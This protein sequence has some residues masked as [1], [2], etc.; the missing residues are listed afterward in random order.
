MHGQHTFEKLLRKL[1]HPGKPF[2]KRPHL[3][4]RA[5]V[6]L[7]GAG[8]T[9]SFLPNRLPAAPLI[10]SANATTKNTAQN[11][12]FVLLAGAPSQIDTFDLKMINGTTPASFAPSTINGMLW[13]TGTMPKLAA[14]LDDIAIVRSVRASAL[15]HGLSQSWVQIGRNPAAVL[16]SIS[17]NIGSVVAI[18][19]DA[20]RKPSQ[21]FP[22]F[23]ALNSAGASSQGYFSS[24]YAPFKVQ[25][26]TSGLRNVTN[27]NG[28][29]RFNTRFDFL[30]KLDDSLRVDSPYG[31][32]VSDY[33]DFY[34][35]AKGLMYNPV[36]TKAFSYTAADSTRYGSTTFGNSCLVAKQVL[37]ANQGTRFIQIT[38]GGWDNH[39]NI[40]Q[41]TVLPQI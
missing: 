41:P 17:P 24:S 37:E 13:P 33:D 5:F 6:N 14:L 7:A 39:T 27:T 22:T 8:L 32:P 30:H 12:I 23:L 31:Q 19:K 28:E 21:V 11:V 18:E 20:E 40:Y 36:V 2:F 29:T 1:P 3:T 38:Q 9:A 10:T 26:A 4:R 34:R 35:A 25:P 16:G 15:V